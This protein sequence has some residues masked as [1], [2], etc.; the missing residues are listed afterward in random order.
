V[1]VTTIL[2]TV[3][4]ILTRIIKIWWNTAIVIADSIST[5]TARTTYIIIARAPIA[6]IAVVAIS[7]NLV[8]P[9][10]IYAGITNTISA[11]TN[12]PVAILGAG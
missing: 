9:A 2:G 1:P 3:N 4:R 7:A 11:Y 8:F 12:R 6:D 5:T 10:G